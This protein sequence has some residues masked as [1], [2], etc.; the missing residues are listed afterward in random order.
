MKAQFSNPLAYV[1]VAAPC[2]VEWNRMRGNE[3]VRFCDQCSL[4]V[5]NLSAMTKRDAETLIMSAE[6]R[7]CVR[8]YR[9]ADG[10]ILTQN[11]PVGLRALKRRVSRIAN[12]TVSA[13]LSFFAGIAG[14]SVYS[15][16]R[17]DP[18]LTL[19]GIEVE[20]Y[21]VPKSEDVEIMGGIGASPVEDIRGRIPIPVFQGKKEW[22]A[23]RMQIEEKGEAWVVAE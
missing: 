16:L 7:L 12:A 9:R 6:G 20:S 21:A 13:V 10:T 8:F 15:S 19:S 22:T 2:S 18:V 23:G 5:Y 1:R 11:C 4:N 3:Q 17:S 14:V